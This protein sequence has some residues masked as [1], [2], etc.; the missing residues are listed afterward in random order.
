M[1]TYSPW[2]IEQTEFVPE[3]EAELGKQLAFSNGYIS[4]YAFFEEYYTGA[5][6]TGT[7]LRGIS[8]PL[9][10]VAEISVRLGEDRL[11]LNTWAVQEFYRCLHKQ[12][13]LL[14]RRFIA[15]S[16]WGHTLKV[17]SSRMLS[18]AQNQMMTMQY[19]IRSLDYSGPISLLSLM[20]NRQSFENWYPLTV[21]IDDQIAQSF[22]QN[23]HENVRIGQAMTTSVLKNGRPLDK[24]RIRIEKRHVLGYSVID[25]ICPNDE[26][27]LEKKVVLMD[28]LNYP[29]VPLVGSVLSLITND[30][31][32][33]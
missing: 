20:G 4:Q 23:T 6:A 8:A 22:C 7:F 2:K 9:P 30:S 12:E 24:P 27:V 5:Q 11:D 28:S 32:A 1:L 21:H 10:P 26:Y 18:M 31:D 25:T 33:R 14:E 15:R 17:S 19:K 16:P 13:P 29:D 3:Q